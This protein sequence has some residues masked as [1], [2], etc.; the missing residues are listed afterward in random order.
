[1]TMMISHAFWKKYSAEYGHEI[2]SQLLNNIAHVLDEV[3]IA[4]LVLAHV[5]LVQYASGEVNDGISIRC[6]IS[7][8]AIHA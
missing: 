4:L 1:M 6:L 8:K 3:G 5:G 2:A 7:R